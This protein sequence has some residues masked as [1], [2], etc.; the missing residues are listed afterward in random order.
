MKKLVLILSTALLILSSCTDNSIK[1]NGPDELNIALRDEVYIDAT[2]KD[3][4]SYKSDNKL[5]ANVDQNGKVSGINIGKTNITLSN[6]EDEL[7]LPVNVSLFKEPT[8]NFGAST[9]EI[10]ELYGEPNTNFGDS[11]YIYGNNTGYS[12]AVWRMNFFFE[13]DRYFES[14]IYIRKE[15]DLDMRIN[16]YLDEKYY[17]HQEVT[18]TLDGK[19][20]TFYIY[21]DNKDPRFANVIVAKQYDSGSFNDILLVYAPFNY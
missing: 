9:K 8:L 21:L 15:L 14:D 17:F 12:W 20:R 5:I 2:S 6:S 10:K 18:D 16:Q 7:K 19:I 13:N 1:Y 3:P 11:I 4:I